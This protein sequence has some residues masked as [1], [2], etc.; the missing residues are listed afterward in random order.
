VVAFPPTRTGMPGVSLYSAVKV[1]WTRQPDRF[2]PNGTLNGPVQ[3]GEPGITRTTARWIPQTS[4]RIQ[5]PGE[6]TPGRIDEPNDVAAAVSSSAPTS[7]YV[8]GQT[9]AD[10]WLVT[11]RP[12][13]SRCLTAS[14]LDG[15]TRSHL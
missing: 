12:P 11:P 2:P 3:R 6:G 8:T 10:R 9:I 14:D 1:A 7:A 5:I 4:R 15:S 13:R